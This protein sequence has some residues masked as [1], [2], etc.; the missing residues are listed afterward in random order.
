MTAGSERDKLCEPQQHTAS[1]SKVRWVQICLLPTEK[2]PMDWGL[3]RACMVTVPSREVSANVPFVQNKQQWSFA[4]LQQIFRSHTSSNFF[5]FFKFKSTVFGVGRHCL[6]IESGRSI[7][8]VESQK[9]GDLR[10]LQSIFPD[11]TNCLR[12]Q[13]C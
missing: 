6:T 12:L 10:T 8:N 5:H 2:G 3:L 13:F 9:A 7:K 1:Q 4:R 11:S